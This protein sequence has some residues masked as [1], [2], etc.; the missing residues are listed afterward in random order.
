MRRSI[1]LAEGHLAKAADIAGTHGLGLLFLGSDEGLREV[2][3]LQG[4]RTGH[5]GLV[6]LARAA[7]D[8]FVTASGNRA[9]ADATTAPSG[10]SLSPGEIQLL[11]FLPTRDTNEDIASRLGI[12]VN[13]VKTRLTRLYRK[14]GVSG[15]K[16]AV[17]AARVRGLID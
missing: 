1:R 3:I 12:S 17:A 16:E 2:A 11:A 4:T 6:S 10:R 13:T 7:G 14:L 9:A 5:D 8:R 15:R